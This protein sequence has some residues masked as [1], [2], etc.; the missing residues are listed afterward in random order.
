MSIEILRSSKSGLIKIVT[1]LFLCLLFLQAHA[2][3]DFT[4][5]SEFGASTSS[6]PKGLNLYNYP[7]PFNNNTTIY[8]KA[9]YKEIIV[10]IYSTNGKLVGRQMFNGLR[11]MTISK[12]NLPDG[13]YLA[14]VYGDNKELGVLKLIIN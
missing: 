2:Q 1:S 7:N 13:I 11:Q 6:I 5:D 4:A 3:S 8:V 14:R 12:N 10:S 9:D